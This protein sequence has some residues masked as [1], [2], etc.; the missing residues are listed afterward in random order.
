MKKQFLNILALSLLM[1]G[2]KAG[3]GE[4]NSATV[5]AD[6][7][8]FTIG[9]NQETTRVRGGITGIVFLKCSTPLADNLQVTWQA[10]L[11]AAPPEMV[12]RKDCGFKAGKTSEA[13]TEE[14][15]A[16]GTTVVTRRLHTVTFEDTFDNEDYDTAKLWIGFQQNPSDYLVALITCDGVVYPFEKMDILADRQI[17]DTN[18]GKTF[19]SG[20]MTYERLVDQLPLDL[21]FDI[22]DLTF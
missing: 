5:V 1:E 16:C 19:W 14:I 4:C 9:L 22:D 3:C 15:G 21:A 11:D 7:P 2:M 18:A 6:F 13:E 8:T 17:E 10:A 12:I 20:T